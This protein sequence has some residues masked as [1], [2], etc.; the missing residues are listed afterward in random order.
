M[1]VSTVMTGS[2]RLKVYIFT[3]EEQLSVIMMSTKRQLV[4][5]LMEEEEDFA[6]DC[7]LPPVADNETVWMRDW[8][9]CRV[10]YGHITIYAGHKRSIS[11]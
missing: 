10:L 5:K 1:T 9:Q 6:F 8:L 7:S 4:M 3:P 11:V 2:G